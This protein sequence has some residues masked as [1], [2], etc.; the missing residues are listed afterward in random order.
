MKDK[1]DANDFSLMQEK[2]YDFIAQQW[3]LENKDP[4]VG[5]FSGHN[6]YPYDK[7]LFEDL[8]TEKMDALD[9]GC[10]PGRN[11]VRYSDF[12]KRIDGVDVSQGCLE[13]AKKYLKSEGLKKE[14]HMLY[15]CNGYDLENIKSNN[16]DIV[17]STIAMQHIPVY[18]IRFNYLKEFYRVLKAGGFISIQMG[19]GEKKDNNASVEY[20]A[21]F[22]ECDKTNGVMD[23]AVG[24][25][26][27]IKEDLCK[28]GFKNFSY[29]VRNDWVPSGWK[30]IIF[31][32]A[33]K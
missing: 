30:E 17:F 14:D 8:R 4:V 25:P 20:Y 10:G 28:I 18:D 9:F 5:N 6:Q 24:D 15:K 29:V 22:W 13:K 21:N 7:Y 26:D 3:S 19:F 2:W 27:Y 12:F 23:T 32:R 33:Q 11:I 1:F 31:F 16:Y